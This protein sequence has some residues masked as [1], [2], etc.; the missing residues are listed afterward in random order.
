MRPRRVLLY[1]YGRVICCAGSS[2]E[3]SH[4]RGL[5]CLPRE[6]KI[7]FMYWFRCTFY[8]EHSH[9]LEVKLLS[10]LFFRVKRTFSKLCVSLSQSICEATIQ[11]GTGMFLRMQRS[12]ILCPSILVSL[13]HE[14]L[15]TRILVRG[16]K[17]RLRIW[18][19]TPLFKKTNTICV[20][21]DVKKLNICKCRHV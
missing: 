3:D 20:S 7:I 5:D 4:I 14:V 1:T 9:W 12:Q 2:S 18:Q 6:S 15:I 11:D 13:F 16:Q 10:S 19:I 17:T 8:R 21:E